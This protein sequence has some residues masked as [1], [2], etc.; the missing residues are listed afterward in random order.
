L[1]SN[2]STTERNINL[3]ASE[4]AEKA[5]LG[6][7]LLDNRV[8]PQAS[9]LSPNDFY[10]DK[11][12]LIYRRIGDLASS[13]RPIDP[14]TLTEELARHRE[15]EK[16]GVAYISDL[17]TGLLATNTI[18]HWVRI[19]REAAARRLAVYSADAIQAAAS[20]KTVSTEQLAARFAE[21]STTLEAY[22]K[23]ATA[24]LSRVADV[25]P[26]AVD[27]LWEG[28]IP[29]GTLTIFDGDPGRGKG[30]VVCDLAARISTGRD[31]PD[32]SPGAIGRVIYLTTEDAVAFVV[33]PRL[34]VARANVDHIFM[35]TPGSETLI[36]FPDSCALLK[37]SVRELDAALVIVDPLSAFLGD[38]INSHKDSDIRRALTPLHQL[39]EGTGASIIGIRHLNKNSG[40]SAMYRGGGSIAIAAAAR[41]LV[42]FGADPD[43]ESD[44]IMGW[45]KLNIAQLPRSMRYQIETAVHPSL[46]DKYGKPTEIAKIRWLG[47]SD[48]QADEL[49]QVALDPEHRSQTDEACAVIRDLFADGKE[50]LAS[51][52]DKAMRAAGISHGTVQN[53]RRRIGV[54][55]RKNAFNGQW[56]WYLTKPL[57]EESKTP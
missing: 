47:E 4:E 38:D 28:R 14:I 26:Q 35:L 18:G 34:D 15:I 37:R 27:W 42:V 54:R 55:S 45:V 3:P 43:H 16:V 12:Q 19:V 11:H 5:I 56:N 33:R 57:D 29:K 25:G 30:L 10:L 9:T 46:K 44:R 39:A 7:I 20:D 2:R 49:V 23:P 51:D 8:Y 36:K 32:G 17:S 41:S 13:S 53:A 48:V 1:H 6:A 22:Q 31:M 50:I 21:A 52:A 40:G 24:Y